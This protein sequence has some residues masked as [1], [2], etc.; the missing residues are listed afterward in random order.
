MGLDGA[1]TRRESEPSSKNRLKYSQEELKELKEGET[2]KDTLVKD[3]RKFADVYF[4]TREKLDKARGILGSDEKKIFEQQLEDAYQKRSHKGVEQIQKNIGQTVDA[5]R[6]L[7]ERYTRD[8][9]KNKDLFGKDDSRKINELKEKE[10]KFRESSLVE[11]QEA[12][13]KLDAELKGLRR[14]RDNLVEIIGEGKGGQAYL[15]RFG[16][17]TEAEK[18][19]YIEATKKTVASFE[20]VSDQLKK[21]D[22]YDE[23]ELENIA[24]RF[25]EAPPDEQ[26]KMLK[27]FEDDLK[28]ENVKYVQENFKK[29]LSER[30]KK[31]EGKLKKAKGLAAKKEV[32]DEMKDEIR[33]ECIEKFNASRLASPEEK[34]EN[35]KYIGEE[36]DPSRL[37]QALRNI[38]NAEATAKKLEDKFTKFPP[39]IQAQYDFYLARFTNK[40][41]NSKELGKQEIVAECEKH[42]ELMAKWGE[43]LK[44]FQD[45]KLLSEGSGAK[46]AEMFQSLS[47]REKEAIVKKSILDDTKQQRINNVTQYEKLKAEHPKLMEKH[48]E[49]YSLRLED[50]VALVESIQLEVKERKEGTEAYNK[51]VDEKVESRLLSPKS[52]K[53]YKD[54]FKNLDSVDEMKKM[55]ENSD[56]DDPRREK[57]LHVF[58]KEIPENTR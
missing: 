36:Q 51:K 44:Q 27:E 12:A 58:E 28:T 40:G 45:N 38:P 21:A 20:K 50:R 56:L 14:I 11:K 57:V 47:L 35:A 29:F 53:A 52:A 33:R 15:K 25:H 1:P 30:Q 37:E 46:Y 32:I 13:K 3:K 5:S 7:L 17:M 22:L 8:L 42:V 6:G 41:T 24:I 54:W 26:A 43:K 19:A 49:F 16:K 9:D 55:L 10:E 34:N 23:D 2:D 31:Y 18:E 48:K 4:D 39:K